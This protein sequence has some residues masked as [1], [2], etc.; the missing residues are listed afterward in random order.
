MWAG[1]GASRR[2]GAG[3]AAVNG[4]RIRLGP[5]PARDPGAEAWVR[6]SEAPGKGDVHT[7]RLTVDVTP[8]LRGRIKVIAFQRGLTVAGMLSA[9]PAHESGQAGAPCPP[10]PPCRSPV[11]SRS[12]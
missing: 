3:M 4:R 8:G 7:A 10:G 5:R 6:G 11:P 12:D 2:G 9:L 1:G